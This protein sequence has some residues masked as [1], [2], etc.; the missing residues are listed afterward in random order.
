MPPASRRSGHPIEEPVASDEKGNGIG[1]RLACNAHSRPHSE[2]IDLDTRQRQC[3]MRKKETTM[4]NEGGTSQLAAQRR[5]NTPG[6]WEHEA[7]NKHNEGTL[8]A[9]AS[10]IQSTMFLQPQP[11]LAEIAHT[12]SVPTN[13]LPLINFRLCGYTEPRAG[14]G[15]IPRTRIRACRGVHGVGARRGFVR[16]S[17]FADVKQPSTPS[18]WLRLPGTVGG[19]LLTASNSGTRG[20]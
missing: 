17:S 2:T 18:S 20:L 19:E 4:P 13:L 6:D 16:P 11:V 12:I 15:M 5:R 8:T 1:I 14:A 3:T 9:A 10:S 7:H